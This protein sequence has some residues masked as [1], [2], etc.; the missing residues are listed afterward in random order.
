MATQVSDGSPSLRYPCQHC[1]K[2]YAWKNSV[3]RHMRLEHNF[4]PGHRFH[5]ADKDGKRDD[6]F[7]VGKDI[8]VEICYLKG[9]PR[10]EIRKWLQEYSGRWVKT[11]EGVSLTLSRWVNFLSEADAIKG[12]I[13]GMKAQHVMKLKRHLGGNYHVSVTSPYRVVEVREWRRDEGDKL[14]RGWKG[15]TLQFPEWEE[16]MLL[17][18]TIVSVLPEI[19]DTIPCYMRGDHQNQMGALNCA[20][21]CPDTY[22][23]Y[24]D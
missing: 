12:A 9:E 5:H 22:M 14:Q 11:A 13:S 15:I 2:T 24:C 18:D 16:L 23:D 6:I 17:A 19:K 20:E 21:C 8:Y 10:I 7:Q 1:S 3:K 4:V